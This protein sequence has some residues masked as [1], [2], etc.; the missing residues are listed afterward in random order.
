LRRERNHPDVDFIEE[1]KI[2]KIAQACSSQND[3]DW[4]LDRISE[5]G[6][7][8]DGRFVYTSSAGEGIDAYIVDTG[9]YI[10]HNDFGGRAKWGAN[11]ADSTNDDC[12]GHGTHVAGT[13]GGTLYGVAKKVTLIAVKVL[14][15]AGSGTNAGV[16]SGVEYVAAQA[17]ITKRPSVA[18]MSLGGG[19][20][21][22]LNNAVAAAVTAGVSFAVAAGNDNSDAC[23]YSP[24]STSTAIS[25]GA[26]TIDETG[27]VTEDVR[28][29]FS[30]F[31]SCVHVFAP[32][33]LIKSAWIGSTTAVKT[34]SGTS[35]ASPHVCGAAALYLGTNKTATPAQVKSFLLANTN[36]DMIDMIC[37]V[38][39]CTKSPNK[40]LYTPCA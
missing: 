5:D 26:T 31:G 1:D 4:G 39:A 40:L 14:T 19:K 9:I 24:A 21:T 12:N 32:G 20:S 3:A 16:I 23:N 27:T 29:S 22:A 10:K 33:Q 38:T 17:K 8:L 15:C 11:Y 34:I 7:D 6:I 30:N 36:N 18:N 13:V 25:T 2:M 28:A 37:S 35:M